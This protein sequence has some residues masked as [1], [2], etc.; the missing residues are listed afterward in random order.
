MLG[1]I[2]QISFQLPKK[3]ILVKNICKINNWNY[4]KIV[5]KTG[6]KIVYHSSKE[7]SAINLAVKAAKKIT[8]GIK[9]IDAL[10]YVTQSPE[11]HLPTNAHTGSCKKKAPW[12]VRLTNNL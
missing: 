3:K 5:E 6:I 9:N 12:K 4:K 1:K 11:Y 8:K 2:S 10:I 7:E